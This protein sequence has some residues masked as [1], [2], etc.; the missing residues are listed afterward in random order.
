MYNFNFYC[1]I[2]NILWGVNVV[3]MIIQ[4]KKVQIQTIIL[5]EIKTSPN[6][7][8]STPP[9]VPEQKASLS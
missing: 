1:F 4:I 6:P 5:D 7:D 9:P 3:E 8:T 2:Q